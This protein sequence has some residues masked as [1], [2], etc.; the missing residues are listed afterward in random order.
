[1]D[2]DLVYLRLSIIRLAILA[3]GFVYVLFK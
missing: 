2:R 1:M 3:S